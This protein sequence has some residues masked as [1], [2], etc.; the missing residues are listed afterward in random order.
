MDIEDDSYMQ[1]SGIRRHKR[2]R[3]VKSKY[4]MS[5]VAHRLEG[6]DLQMIYQGHQSVRE[7]FKYL[8]PLA[9]RWTDK[10]L[11]DFGQVLINTFDSSYQIA[12]IAPN[13]LS[14]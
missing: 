1:L 13:S 2:V 3:L 12:V 11:F 4:Y 14:A 10:L 8:Q 9:T 7:C 5:E 6:F